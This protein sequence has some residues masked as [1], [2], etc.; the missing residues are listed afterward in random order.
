MPSLFDFTEETGKLKEN[1]KFWITDGTG[2][3]RDKYIAG[4]AIIPSV[5]EFSVSGTLDLS[6]YRGDV[7]VVAT[8]GSVTITINNTLPD[9]RR[10]LVGCEDTYG[11]VTITGTLNREID[12]GTYIVYTYRDGEAL[13][14]LEVMGLDAHKSDDITDTNSVHGIQQGSGNGFDSDLLDGRQSGNSSGDIPINNGT[15][16]TN[17]NADKLDGAD[18]STDGTFAGDSDNAVPTEKA[19]KTYV[20]SKHGRVPISTF[21]TGSSVYDTSSIFSALD[22]VI[23]NTGDAILVTGGGRAFNGD[24]TAIE[25]TFIASK[26]TRED[27]DT[28]FLHGGDYYGRQ[29]ITRIN[30]NFITTKRR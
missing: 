28:I 11:S 27:S 10:L 21:A 9:G 12:E 4:D 20:Q 5:V 3:S 26:A 1:V 6:D 18:K 25:I 14:S 19:V 13:S 24:A 30:R 15:L 23:P 22:S 7:F 29:A 17:L 2:T 8:A 16:N